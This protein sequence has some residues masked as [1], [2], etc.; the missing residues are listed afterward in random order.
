MPE[1]CGGRCETRDEV[2][3]IS[4]EVP[5]AEIRAVLLHEMIHESLPFGEGTGRPSWQRCGE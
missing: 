4:T 1:R 5:E 2:L 3:L